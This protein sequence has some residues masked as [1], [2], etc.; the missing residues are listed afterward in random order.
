MVLS[1][2]SRLRFSSDAMTLAA[3]VAGDSGVEVKLRAAV[4]TQPSDAVEVP[5]EGSIRAAFVAAMARGKDLGDMKDWS[6]TTA[7]AELKFTTTGAGRTWPGLVL[8]TRQFEDPAPR[9]LLDGR[10]EELSGLKTTEDFSAF[11]NKLIADES[12]YLRAEGVESSNINETYGI[13][14]ERRLALVEELKAAVS[15][16]GLTGEARAEAC[17]TGASAR[18]AVLDGR[19][20]RRT[21]AHWALPSRHL[22]QF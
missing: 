6:V 15:M 10:S 9:K 20:G 19:R 8:D 1:E 3:E 2:I 16:T 18:T 12:A 5:E 22:F 11:V 4:A 14:N 13:R 17:A 7:G 21:T